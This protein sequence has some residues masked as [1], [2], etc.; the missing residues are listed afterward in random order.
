LKELFRD[1]QR[2]ILDQILNTTLDEIAGDYRRIYERH[3][4]LN[5]FLRELNIPQ[6]RVLHTAA[7]FVLNSNLRQAF[8]GNMT[9]LK[10][11]RTLLEEAKIANVKLDGTVHRYVLEQTLSRLG[12]RLWENPNDLDLITHLDEVTALVGSLPF[13]VDLW[14]VQNVYYSLLQT[15]YPDN[16]EKAAAGDE[17]ARE[18]IARF[19][20]LGDKLRVRREE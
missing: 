15:V 3:A 9:D 7:E 11:I 1:K 10:Q 17:E 16:L 19:N 18:W 5:R 13:E 8:A 4:H 14:K 2:Q 12:E 20:D 6:P